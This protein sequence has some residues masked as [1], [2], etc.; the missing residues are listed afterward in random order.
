MRRGG[1]NV[2]SIEV[3]TVLPPNL[4]LI[5]GNEDQLQQVFVNLA[6]N[7]VQAMKGGGRLI[8]TAHGSP[9]WLTLTVADTGVGIPPEHLSRVFE[10]FFT[11]K[12]EGEGTGLGLSI[13][14]AIVDAHGGR[15]NVTSRIGVGTVFTL[16]FPA[17]KEENG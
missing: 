1:V 3:E 4:P 5:R 14:H 15:I 10:P 13:I 9:E 6:V 16:E 7:A 17:L 12:P 8:L 2:S 11:T